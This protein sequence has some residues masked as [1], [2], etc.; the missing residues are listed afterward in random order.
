MEYISTNDQVIA[1]GYGMQSERTED[2]GSK[3]L[4]FA[5]FKMLAQRK[6]NLFS[7]KLRFFGIRNHHI[8]FYSNSDFSKNLNFAKA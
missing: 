4:K 8:V 1:L 7:A 6:V 3:R 5:R 2:H